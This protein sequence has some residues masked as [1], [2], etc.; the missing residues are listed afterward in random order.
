MTNARQNQHFLVIIVEYTKFTQ[1]NSQ[2]YWIIKILD[3]DILARITVKGLMTKL[4]S[5][6]SG[7]I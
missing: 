3:H 6:N 7:I 1:N 4:P 5:Q 2:T